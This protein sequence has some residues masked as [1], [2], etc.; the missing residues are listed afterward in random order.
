MAAGEG[1]A[2]VYIILILAVINLSIGY[3]LGVF[4]GRG[5]DHSAFIGSAMDVVADLPAAL[6]EWVTFARSRKSE[7]SEVAGADANPPPPPA[8]PQPRQTDPAEAQIVVEQPQPQPSV[9]PDLSTASVEDCVAA[10][11]N[12]LERYRDELAGIDDRV[13]ECAAAPDREAIEH[14]ISDFREANGHYLQQQAT[15]AGVLQQYEAQHGDGAKSSEFHQALAQQAA[16]IE[17]ANTKLEELD[18]DADL[19]GSCDGLLKQTETLANA[20]FK[21]RDLTDEVAVDLSALNPDKAASP[22]LTPWVPG[23]AS[24]VDLHSALRSRWEDESLRIEPL[25]MAVI[26]TDRLQAINQQHGTNVGDRILKAVAQIVMSSIGDDD[27]AARFEGQKLLVMLPGAEARSATNLIERIRQRVERTSFQRSG[28]PLQVTVSC[29]VA[30]TGKEDTP[31]SVIKRA[32]TALQEA[33]RYGRNRTFFQEGDF[34]APAIPPNFTIE[35]SVL[36]V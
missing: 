5:F 32:D 18:L 3:A 14:C 4:W 8:R 11:K 12:E 1:W 16:Q 30:D 7:V 26:D 15:V 24:L 9:L 31:E 33:K 13:R 28:K 25:T 22:A 27:M 10:F 34:P 2:L 21:V 29:G 20:A 23:V 17:M 36:A 6:R 35:T 19:T